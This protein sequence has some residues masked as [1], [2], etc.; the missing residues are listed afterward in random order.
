MASHPT[1]AHSQQRGS[2]SPA[3][4]GVHSRGATR[5]AGLGLRGGS[6]WKLR[7]PDL[8]SGYTRHRRGCTLHQ[9]HFHLPLAHWRF[10]TWLGHN[11]L[12]TGA[13]KP[14]LAKRGRACP[15]TCLWAREYTARLPT[16]G[17]RGKGV[18]QL[19]ALRSG[20]AQPPFL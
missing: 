12:L 20:S 13:P 2:R 4:G 7:S 11:G 18:C 8:R 10:P 17:T 9:L 1:P 5:H 6:V 14:Q 16:H 19:P 15:A 3:A